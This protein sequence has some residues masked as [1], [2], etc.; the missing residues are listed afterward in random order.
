MSIRD[1]HLFQ[2]SAQKIAVAAKA[3][4]VYHREREKYWLE[5]YEMSL[6]RVKATAGVEFKEYPVTG[7]MRVSMEVSYGD[8]PALNRMQE[9]YAKLG[10]HREQAERFETDAR[11][12]ETQGEQSYDLSTDDVHY[13]RLGGQPR[14]SD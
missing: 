3:E 9:A 14:E 6:G 11:V 2:F 8:L 12:Y 13:F 5:E 10:R 7:G 1:K 4:A